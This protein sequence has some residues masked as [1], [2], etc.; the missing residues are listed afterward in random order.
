MEYAS[1]AT[2]DAGLTT[3]IIGTALGALNS[4]LFNGGLGGLFGGGNA[5]A[6]LS[7]M[8]AG[9]ALAAAL[10]AGGRCSEDK[11]VSRYELGLVPRLKE[12]GADSFCFDDTLFGRVLCCAPS[13]GFQFDVPL[14]GLELPGFGD[15]YFVL[16]LP[17][18]E[19]LFTAPTAKY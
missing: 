18:S 13:L 19:L 14:T 9:A 4:G 1:K 5:A 8:A 16:L 7:G 12:T 10:G 3:G 15:F 17:F 11:P 6:D 2:G